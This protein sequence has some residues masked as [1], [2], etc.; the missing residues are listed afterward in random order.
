MDAALIMFGH[1]LVM[2][3]STKSRVPDSIKDTHC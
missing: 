2:T 1:Y 3:A